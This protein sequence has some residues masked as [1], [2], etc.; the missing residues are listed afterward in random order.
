M[1]GL[2]ELPAGV[3]VLAVA[4]VTLALTAVAS[5]T[6]AAAVLIPVAHALAGALGVDPVMLV[7]VVALASS[8]DFALVIGTPP[9]M[10]AYSTGLFT[11]AQIFRL[12]LMVDLLGLLALVGVVVPLWGLLGL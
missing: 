11:A 8:L 10:M 2:R 3:G 12:G 6:A 4:A 1:V 5:N 9:T 7:M